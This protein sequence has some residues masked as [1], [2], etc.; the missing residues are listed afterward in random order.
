MIVIETPRLILRHLTLEDT[1]A[2]ATIYA[3]RIVMKFA[4][5]TSSVEETKQFVEKTI[6][7]YEQYGYDFGLR[8]TI[9][10]PDNQFIGHCGI[11]PPNNKCS[12]LEI[13]YLLAK[14]YWGMGLATEAAIAIRDYGFEKTGC[15]RLIAS[16][17]HDN[18]ASQK[19]ALKT[20]LTYERDIN[21]EGEDLRVYAIERPCQS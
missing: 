2:L 10:K 11:K 12:E 9:Y 3:D 6:N 1:E 21:I 19:V 7:R 13:G 15:N 17:D 16:I 20:G 18:I 5:G 14:E 4:G 8:A